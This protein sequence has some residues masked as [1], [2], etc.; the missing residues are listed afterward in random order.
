MV[1]ASR[2][3]WSEWCHTVTRVTSPA[4]GNT[5]VGISSLTLPAAEIAAWIITPSCG[6]ASTFCG[7]VRDHSEGRT[8]I[9]RLDYEAHVTL[10]E[11]RL[12]A[13]AD[14]ARQRW[15]EIGR[16]AL[17]HRTG[18]LKVGDVAVVVAVSTPHRGEAFEATSW[19]IDTLKATVPIWKYEVWDGGEGWGQCT[20]DLVDV[21][22]LDGRPG[23]GVRHANRSAHVAPNAVDD[24]GADDLVGQR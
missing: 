18:S 12:I 8:G 20:H 6:A 21:A 5:W 15:P 24:T 17:L 2:L 10:V 13:I 11:P 14:A 16:V 3:G 9:V 1:P 23:S 19:C 4:N 7:T 22:S